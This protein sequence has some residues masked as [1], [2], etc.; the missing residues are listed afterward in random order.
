MRIIN[1]S[2]SPKLQTE[3]IYSLGLMH[4]LCECEDEQTQEYLD[5]LL[6]LINSHKN[7]AVTS[8]ALLNWTLVISIQP[9]RSLLS[10]QLPSFES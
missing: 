2:K 7:N 1:T 4:Y 8:A 9:S 6:T 3:A 5:S 10:D